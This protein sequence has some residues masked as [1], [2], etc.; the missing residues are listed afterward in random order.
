[1]G[2]EGQDLQDEGESRE[3]GPRDQSGASTTKGRQKVTVRISSERQGVELEWDETSSDNVT[4]YAQGDDGEWHNTSEMSNDGKALVSYPAGF[5]GESLVEVR[6]ADGT[7][8][9]SGTIKVG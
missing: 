2:R 4:V 5:R 8:I 3:T 6:S 9:D 1:M 7:V